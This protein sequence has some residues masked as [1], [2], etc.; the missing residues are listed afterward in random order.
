MGAFDSNDQL[1]QYSA[2]PRQTVKWWKVFFHL[3]NLPMVNSFILYHGWVLF[4]NA[5]KAELRKVMQSEFR[6]SN[7]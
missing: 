6:A 5:T 7:K 4:C 3:L 1:M 2:F